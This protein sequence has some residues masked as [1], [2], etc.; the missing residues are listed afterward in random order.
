MAPTHQYG[1]SQ[2]SIISWAPNRGLYP[3]QRSG[4]FHEKSTEHIFSGT[5]IVAVQ[6]P[7][8]RNG[9]QS[10]PP[11]WQVLIFTRSNRQQLSAPRVTNGVEA[12]F[13]AIN[14]ELIAT[15]RSLR[16]IIERISYIAIP[17]DEFLFNSD[18]RDSM[19]FE[20]EAFSKSRTYFWALQ[21]L[22]ILNDC[23]TS[24]ISSWQ[25]SNSLSWTP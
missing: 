5:S 9:A 21:S 20:D 1:R 14:N 3:D 6:V 15:R 11:P 22:R 7:A 25:L 4:R 8:L 18:L 13:W 10:I 16:E 24:I 12:Y 23:I 19:L 17:D 2:S